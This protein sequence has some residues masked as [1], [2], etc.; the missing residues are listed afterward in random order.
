MAKGRVSGRRQDGRS[1]SEFWGKHIAAREA[2][3]V[4]IA[5]Y[6]RDH[7]LS[8]ASYHW[9]KGELKRRK[10]SVVFAEVR[11]PLAGG[12]VDGAIEVVMGGSRVVRVRSGFDE[13][14][15]AR[16]LFVVERCGC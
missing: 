7:E 11:M 9:W 13:A 2:S 3:G 8:C 15:L 1:R 10:I 4:S 16:V 5:Q 6:C 14:T 12:A